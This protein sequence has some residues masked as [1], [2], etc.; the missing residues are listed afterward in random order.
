MFG[1][2]KHFIYSLLVLT[3]VVSVFT[4][5]AV[6]PVRAESM[7]ISQLVEL[8]ITIG[9]I[10]PDKA[11]TARTAIASLSTATTTPIVSSVVSTTAQATSTASYLQVLSPNGGEK[12]EID[13]DLPY[14]ITWGSFGLPD[15]RV[16]LVA[17]KNTCN[18]SFLPTSSV[19]DGA[20][21]LSVLLK[22][23]KCFDLI[24]G[25]TTLLVH[26]TYRVRISA[27]DSLGKE[28]EDYSDAIFKIL[29][30][31]IPSIKVTSPNGGESF[32]RNHE[33]VVNYTL[34]NA[35]ISSGSLIYYYILDNNDN[36]VSN[37]HKT[38]RNGTFDLD[39]PSSLPAGAYKLKLKITTNDRVTIEDVS[40]NFFWISTGL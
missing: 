12:W 27:K 37:Y 2:K 31:P 1:M 34:K 16:A 8:L 20:H 35:T 38:V 28:V 13:L 32:I 5:G 22:K 40:D 6:V 14:K 10:A 23:A 29:P 11:V 25:T 21:T 15:T 3:I 39:I 30:E 36:V 18:L 26:G 17:G 9:V 7:T 24:T 4:F 33:Y 19:K